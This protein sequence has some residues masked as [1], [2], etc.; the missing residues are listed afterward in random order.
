MKTEKGNSTNSLFSLNED[1]YLNLAMNRSAY[2]CENDE[3][4]GICEIEVPH[5]GLFLNYMDSRNSVGFQHKLSKSK[6]IIILVGLPA[7][8]KSTI[9]NQ[10]I[11][12]L[13]NNPVTSNLR[14]EIFNAGKL[15]RD[16]SLTNTLQL[17]N[18]SSEDIFNPKN[19]DKKEK[20]AQLTFQ[21]LVNHIDN[22][23]CDLAIFDA[24]NST[25]KRRE[26]LFN[27]IRQ[28][29]DSPV[30]NFKLIPIVFQVTCIDHNMVR[31]N[32]HQKSF[33]EDYFDKPY[34]LAI[35]DFAKRLQNYKDQF[36][37]F[38][39]HEFD[40]IKT[41]FFTNI[42]YF[43]FSILNNGMDEGEILE[44][45]TQEKEN[46]DNSTESIIKVIQSFTINYVST[47]GYQYIK[48]VNEFFKIQKQSINDTKTM[49]VLTSVVDHKY[50][51]QLKQYSN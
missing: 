15:R 37:P 3:L 28:Y 35:K 18:S 38:T 33:N 30:S 43:F 26:N 5:D 2:Y 23:M 51:D 4:E 34:H 50:L 36:V 48:K 29:D 45:F 42:D 44:S 11:H 17:A 19:S 14:C 49:N 7:T 32:I 6:Y 1:S 47:Y 39:S 31:Y 41:H 21:K 46:K 9:A 20:F 40:K 8:G 16:M 13:Q 24:T 10:L 12:S 27:Q 25:I 22:D